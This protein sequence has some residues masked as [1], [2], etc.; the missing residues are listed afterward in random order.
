MFTPRNLALSCPDCNGPKRDEETLVDPSVAT[1]PS[2]GDGFLI[3]HP[4]FDY[5]Y[6]HI[7][8]AGV[9]YT[10]VEG[11]DKGEWTIGAC[12]LG[13]FAQL[14]IG[15]PDPIEEDEFEMQVE[16]ADMG[17]F[18]SVKAISDVLRFRM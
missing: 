13:R 10:A 12:D 4:H 9:V 17:D 15:W 7:A 8:V 14:K 1:Y 11:S 5:Y 3:V 2:S 16:Q 6:D 18:S